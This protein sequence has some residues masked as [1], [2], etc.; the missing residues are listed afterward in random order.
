MDLEQK[1]YELHAGNLNTDTV[2]SRELVFLD[3]YGE[4]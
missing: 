1:W 3:Y 2:S 4:Y